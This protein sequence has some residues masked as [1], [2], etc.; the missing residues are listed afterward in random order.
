MLAKRLGSCWRA[1]VRARLRL[2]SEYP[3][4]DRSRSQFFVDEGVASGEVD[5]GEELLPRLG[6]RCYRRTYR[7]TPVGSSFVDEFEE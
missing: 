5:E 2:P 3:L 7:R 4:R 1:L 6:S